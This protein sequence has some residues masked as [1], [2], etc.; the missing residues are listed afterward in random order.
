MLFLN[1][2]FDFKFMS[3]MEGT[4]TMYGREQAGTEIVVQIFILTHFKHF[5]PLLHS[6]LVLNALSGL[7]LISE[8]FPSKLR[9]GEERKTYLHGN[10]QSK[11]KHK[12][13]HYK[14]KNSLGGYSESV[15]YK[16]LK[17][18][19]PQTSKA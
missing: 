1:H 9:G 19:N 16:G 2:H 12:E 13:L 6:H 7:F 11:V 10:S 17:K 15:D 14:Q 8:L 18:K 4:L 5:L 3:Q